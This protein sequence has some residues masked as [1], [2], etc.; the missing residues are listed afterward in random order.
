MLA[1]GLGPVPEE[2]NVVWRC[3]HFFGEREVQPGFC[4]MCDRIFLL[5]VFVI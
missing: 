2:F 4:M 5:F 1:F 3:F